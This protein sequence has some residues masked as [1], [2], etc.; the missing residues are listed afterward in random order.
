[1]DGRVRQVPEDVEC[2]RTAFDR[3]L[4]RKKKLL[5]ENVEGGGAVPRA[6]RAA[7]RPA[8]RWVAYFPLQSR[9][10][11]D[12]CCVEK[13]LDQLVPIGS[14]RMSVRVL[15]AVTSVAPQNKRIW[16][17]LAT[18]TRHCGCKMVS[19]AC[20]KPCGVELGS[21]L[22]CVHAR[23]SPRHGVDPRIS[24]APSL[25]AVITPTTTPASTQFLR[26]STFTFNEALCGVNAWHTPHNPARMTCP[27]LWTLRLC[28][29]SW[30][31]FKKITLRM[32]S[33]FHVIPTITKKFTHTHNIHP[34]CIHTTH[35]T[36][37]P[38]HSVASHRIAHSLGRQRRS[39]CE[40]E[41]KRGGA[42]RKKPSG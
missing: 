16:V 35:S 3:K 38:T 37:S 15:Y 23:T 13:L 39:C 19:E 2:L 5:I 22:L 26:Q 4:R 6:P 40:I 10:F 24:S 30:Q 27:S 29:C 31:L 7:V 9:A 11:V 28:R 1:M 8:E 41:K 32:R 17:T 21:P 36:Q 34:R 20:A 42:K 25:Q 33:V 12:L 14:G 18:A